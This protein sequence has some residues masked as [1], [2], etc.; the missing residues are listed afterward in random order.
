MGGALLG[1]YLN[2]PTGAEKQASNLMNAFAQQGAE[3]SQEARNLGMSY[4]NR[5]SSTLGAPTNYFQSL[6]SGDRAATTAALAPDISRI[7]GTTQQALQSA[8][9][10]A[11]RGGGRS[12]LLFNLPQQASAQVSG[13]FNTIRPE[14]AKGLMD[15]AGMQ[16]QVGTNIFGTAP[17]FMAAGLQGAESLN[18]AEAAR[19]QREAGA[20]AGVAGFLQN[21]PWGSV[22]NRTPSPNI[23]APATQ[24]TLAFPWATGGR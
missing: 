23:M 12:S 10:L 6:L 13:L 15:I 11:P 14:A 2:R 7:T 24:T 9:T 8:S 18:A 17:S 5:F 19:R 21:L 1:K 20:G 16:G 4:L 3:S 22:F